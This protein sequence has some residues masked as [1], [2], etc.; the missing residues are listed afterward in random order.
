VTTKLVD[1]I[2]TAKSPA[3]CRL[4]TAA[5]RQPDD[6]IVGFNIDAEQSQEF[7]S[8]NQTQCR[9]RRMRVKRKRDHR[10]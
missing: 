1:R 7:S 8:S 9:K 2:N 10:N 3:I 5:Q 4:P 6:E